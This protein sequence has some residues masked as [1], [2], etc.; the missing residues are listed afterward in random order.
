[1][2]LV[3]TCPNDGENVSHVFLKSHGIGH[4]KKIT[5]RKI[6]FVESLNIFAVAIE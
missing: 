1:M 2:E 4:I 3:S 5:S 6:R